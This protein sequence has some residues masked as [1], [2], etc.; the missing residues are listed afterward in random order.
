MP[1]KI[2]HTQRDADEC[3][4]LAGQASPAVFFLQVAE[5]LAGSQNVG[6]PFFY[7]P[8][9]FLKQDTQSLRSW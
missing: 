5:I 9:D 4:K 8:I 6:P 3:Q 2:N 7:R 1:D